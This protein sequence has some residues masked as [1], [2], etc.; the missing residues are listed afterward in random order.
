M[1]GLKEKASQVKTAGV[2][3]Y[4]S[5]RDKYSSSGAP[6]TVKAKPPPPPPPPPRKVSGKQSG[7][8]VPNEATDIDRIDWAN[9]TYEDKQAFFSWL[10]EFFA[11]YLDQPPPPPRASASA[12]GPNT[13][14][15]SP[16]PSPFIPPRRAN[17]QA[18]QNAEPDPPDVAPAA[19]AVGRRSLP[20]VLSQHGPVRPSVLL[21]N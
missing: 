3:S 17:P 15:Q 11:R 2:K 4:N 7:T 21:L 10:D 1:S 5:A 12:D 14:T 18:T 16:R 13:S 6:P 20:P 9:L 8:G 19:P